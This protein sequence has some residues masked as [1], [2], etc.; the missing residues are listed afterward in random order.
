MA[1]VDVGTLRKIRSVA[2]VG[3]GPSGFYAAAA[4]LQAGERNIRV[5]M[6]DRLPTPWGLVRAGVAPDH[7]KIKSV[8][9]QFVRTAKDPNYRF[10]GNVMFGVDVSRAELVDR[11]DA[12]I[13]AVGAQTERRLGVPGEDLSGSLAAVDFVGW[14]WVPRTLSRHATC[15]YSW[16]RPPS[17]SRRRWPNGRAGGC[18]G[19]GL[20]AGGR[21]RAIG[22]DGGRC[23]ARRTRAARAA[24]WRGPVIRRWSRHSR[25]SVPIEAFGD[26][27]RSR[28]PHRCPDD[29]DVGGGEDGV[30]GGGELAVAVADEEPEPRRRG[31]RGP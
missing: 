14:L 29:A 31:R 8:S 12:V 10:F 23:S 25:R 15:R 9:E 3:S 30:E 21:D 6:F 2:I 5:D 13:Y 28:C 27:I 18:A 16:M 19:V 20:R 22:A 24:R 17:R 7:P 26:R 11:Y 4:L 1:S